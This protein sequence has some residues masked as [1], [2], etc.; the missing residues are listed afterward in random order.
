M[1]VTTE[2]FDVESAIREYI[3]QVIHMSLATVSDNKPWVC[4]V[5]YAYDDDLN[6]YFV[7]GVNRRHSE[8]LRKNQHVAGNIVTQHFLNQKVRGV[9]FE[10]TAKELH[11]LDEIQ[12]AYAAYKTR[13]ADSPQLVQVAQSQG[14]ARFYKVTVSDWYVLDG[15]ANDPPQKF[16]ID[17]RP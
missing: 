2:P 5:H 13:Y 8:E 7:S 12:L 11:E 10:G 3:P 6:L 9:Y 17:W 1:S 15:Y 14:G 4:E 16:H